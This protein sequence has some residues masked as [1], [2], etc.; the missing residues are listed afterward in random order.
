[1]TADQAEELMR[2]AAAG[3]AK[4]ELGADRYEFLMRHLLPLPYEWTR[5][6]ISRYLVTH[7]WLSSLA[8]ICDAVGVTERAADDLVRAA[9]ERGQLVR[10]LR[11]AS[12]WSYV[13]P[14]EPLP[15][16]A[17]EAAAVAA[18]PVVTA[19]PPRRALPDPSL[20]MGRIVDRDRKIAALI[21]AKRLPPARSQTPQPD[22]A[23]FE[24]ELAAIEARYQAQQPAKEQSR[25]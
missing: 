21:G 1:M 2:S 13:G 12:G 18:E 16:G 9:L 24:A 23:A 19:P 7:K 10:D 6:R 4:Q 11:S 17:V 3:A 5:D 15:Q 20:V 25:A 22:P 8:E 14:G